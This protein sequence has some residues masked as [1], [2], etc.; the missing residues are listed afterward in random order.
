MFI[1]LGE[2]PSDTLAVNVNAHD[3]IF[4]RHGFSAKNLSVVRK[5]I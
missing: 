5:R 2:N 3:Y 1:K 4:I